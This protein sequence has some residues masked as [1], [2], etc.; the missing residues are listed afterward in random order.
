MKTLNLSGDVGYE[1][2][3]QKIRDQ[4]DM[5]SSEK[6]QIIINSPGG[7]VFEA[8]EI[9]DLLSQYKGHKEIILAPLAASAASYIAMVGDSI[10]AFKNSVFMAHPVF[11]IAMG[12]SDDMRREAD[13]MDSLEN[14]IVEAYQK[15]IKKD[16]AEIKSLMKN[17]LWLIGWEQLTDLGLIDDIIDSPDEIEIEDE[18]I[19]SSLQESISG[20]N[21]NLVKMKIAKTENRMRKDNIKPEYE[22]LVAKLEK[23]KPAENKAETIPENPVVVNNEEATMT[24]QEF[25][26]KSPDAKAEYESL[27]ASAQNQAVEN[28]QKNTVEILTL[29]N[30]NISPVAFDALSKN[31]TSAEYAVEKLKAENLKR[32]GEKAN[33]FAALVAPQ[34]PAAQAPDIA[35]ANKAKTHEEVEKQIEDVAE[36]FF[37]GKQ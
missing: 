26:E 32:E 13:I 17:E 33:P 20:A 2:T 6:L 30:V 12:N 8:F 29:E 9:Y 23:K 4:I 35:I 37:G 16:K 31:K 11:S 3:A 10:K 27:L 5:G 7:Y 24:L 22:R 15:R 19:K 25:L 1:I 21:M 34:T 36:I 18:T 14:I 28:A